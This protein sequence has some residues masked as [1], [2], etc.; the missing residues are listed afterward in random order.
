MAKRLIEVDDET[1]VVVPIEPT[2]DMLNAA[3]ERLC[4]MKSVTHFDD[5]RETEMFKA[6]CSVCAKIG[7]HEPD[8]D[9]L[10]FDKPKD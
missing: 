8:C 5:H 7:E 4:E 9:T 3:Q 1:H 2:D 10:Q 6:M